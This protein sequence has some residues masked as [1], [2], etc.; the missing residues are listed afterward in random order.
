MRTIPVLPVVLFH[1]G[2]ALLAATQKPLPK[3]F[4]PPSTRHP[5]DECCNNGV[6]SSPSNLQSTITLPYFKDACRISR[7]NE[8]G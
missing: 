7:S 6:G 3:R 4:S 2:L 8:S 1:A 5:T